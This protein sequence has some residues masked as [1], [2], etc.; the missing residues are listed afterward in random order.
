MKSWEVGVPRPG[1]PHNGMHFKLWNRREGSAASPI[2]IPAARGSSATVC[3]SHRQHSVR[4][5]RLT[6][7]LTRLDCNYTKNQ[8]C[9]D[10]F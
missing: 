5:R 4:L 2:P 6:R 3:R 10:V 7:T 9:V 8:H 1:R